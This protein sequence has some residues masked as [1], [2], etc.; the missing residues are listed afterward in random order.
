MDWS[1]YFDF[2]NED[3][4]RLKGTWVRIETVLFTY[5]FEGRSTQRPLFENLEDQ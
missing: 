3:D 5:P 2:L 1:R 4:I